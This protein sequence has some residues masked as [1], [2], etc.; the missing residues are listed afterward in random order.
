MPITLCTMF[1][2]RDFS[3]RDQDPFIDVFLAI[4]SLIRQGGM[5]LN[6]KFCFLSNYWSSILQDLIIRHQIICIDG[7]KIPYCWNFLLRR[8]LPFVFF[9]RCLI[10][11]GAGR[12]A[13]T[14]KFRVPVRFDSFRKA[15]SYICRKVWHSLKIDSTFLLS[16]DNAISTKSIIIAKHSGFFVGCRIDIF[17]FTTKP[18]FCNKKITVPFLIIT[19]FG[20][21]PRIKKSFE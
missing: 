17:V 6:Y 5:W 14:V 21:L 12:I 20:I 1:I 13:S 18:P 7:P 16:R 9:W 11:K 19:S 10:Y 4:C 3:S 8:G 2:C 15:T